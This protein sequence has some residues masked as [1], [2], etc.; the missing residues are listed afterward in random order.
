M[1]IFDLIK[2]IHTRRMTSNAPPIYQGFINMHIYTE[3]NTMNLYPFI[4]SISRESSLNGTPG[5]SCYCLSL[6][7]VTSYWFVI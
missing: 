5:N 1:K 2:Y 7:I 3:I 6:N 4:S